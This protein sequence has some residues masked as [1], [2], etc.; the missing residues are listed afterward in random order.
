MP[1]TPTWSSSTRAASASAPR[2]S[3]T[4]ASGSCGSSP[5][6]QGHDPIVAVAGC[7]AQQE[8]EALLKRSPGVA[9][10]I[11]GTQAI[12]RLPM[13]V[14]QAAEKRTPAEHGRPA[15]HR[16]RPVRRR[17]V[18]A[19]RH[20]AGRSGQGLRHDHRGLQ[21][22]LQLLRRARTRAATSGCGPRPTSSRRCARRPRRGPPGSAA[23]R[24]DR[25][26][27]RRRPDDP[28]CD[29]TALLEAIHDVAASSASGSPART[30]GTSAPVPRDD[31]AAAEDLPA[32]ASAGAIRLHARAGGDAPPVHARELSGSGRP[33]SGVAA[34]RRACRPI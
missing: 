19:G 6:S 26:P 34:G 24:A 11:V 7:V 17:D 3:S 1:P 30:R 32:P 25:E 5:P 20:A 2:R 27:L 29:F 21:R 23:A 12:R 16:P 18:S 31:G 33:D 10:V 28:S 8:G 14:E 15:P 22:V 4:R 9:D 13:L